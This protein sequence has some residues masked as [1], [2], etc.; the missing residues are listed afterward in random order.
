MGMLSN[1]VSSVGKSLFGEAPNTGQAQ[2][3]A[4][5]RER[6]R[7]LGIERKKKREARFFTTEG[8]GKR[9]FAALSF[10]NEDE[11]DELS[12]DRRSLRASGRFAD[13]RL[14]L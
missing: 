8:E 6:E 10:G 4:E 7:L 14:V 5:Q 2:W 11:L 9:R 13:D 12:E 3:K 1:L